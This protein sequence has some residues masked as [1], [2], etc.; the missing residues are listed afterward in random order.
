MD[1]S[2]MGQQVG[3]AKDHYFPKGTSEVQKQK[4]TMA[5]GVVW[6]ERSAHSKR[7]NQQREGHVPWI[8]TSQEKLLHEG[9]A[10]SD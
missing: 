4:Q 10:P 9:N 7:N 8:D 5:N 3:I 6:T 2:P 1:P